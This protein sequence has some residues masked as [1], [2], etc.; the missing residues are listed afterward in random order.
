[1]TTNEEVNP[2]DAIVETTNSRCS[3]SDST[4]AE[5]NG[6]NFDVNHNLHKSEISRNSQTKSEET[7]KSQRTLETK[8]NEVQ[9]DDVK[10][11]N[12]VPK[13][14]STTEEPFKRRRK[15][16]GLQNL[17]AMPTMTTKYLKEVGNSKRNH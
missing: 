9:T 8:N 4:S 15:P 2:S 3:D 10:T 16:A 1:M 6:A 11:E 14:P 13:V 7:A 12:E 5:I 17:D